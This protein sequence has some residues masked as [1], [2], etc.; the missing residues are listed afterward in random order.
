MPPKIRAKALES[1]GD[2]RIND[3]DPGFVNSPGTSGYIH[4]G[5]LR[6]RLRASDNEGK[7]VSLMFLGHEFDHVEYF[8]RRQAMNPALRV[9]DSV[10]H[11]IDKVLRTEFQAHGFQYDVIQGMFKAAGSPNELF[12]FLIRETGLPPE[13]ARDLAAVL[14]I[15]TVRGKVGTIVKDTDEAVRRS[16][17]RK[18]LAALMTSGRLE[19]LMK[20][21]A[22][23][24]SDHSG[25][26]IV[27]QIHSASRGRFVM[28]S[29]WFNGYI[30]EHGP[31]QAAKFIALTVG[32]YVAIKALHASETA[33]AA[34]PAA[35]KH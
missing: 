5:D 27:A 1:L 26:H 21:A 13:E 32:A 14:D 2:V 24:L 33:P 29:L 31:M 30:R 12:R 19:K 17:D 34:T 20:D 4:T 25:I 35:Q 6:I 23:L 9:I 15:T 11:P 10:Y 3:T 8:A 22:K 16:G 7:I 28:D 18:H